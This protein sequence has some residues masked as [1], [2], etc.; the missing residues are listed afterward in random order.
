MADHG[1][2]VTGLI[3]D[4]APR[5]QIRLIRI[6]NDYGG[7]DL[8]NIYAAL[9]DLEVELISGPIRRLVINLSLNIMPDI[10]RLP[11]VWF[12]HRQ[13]P[14]TQWP[15]AVGALVACLGGVG[16]A[17]CRRSGYA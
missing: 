10:R 13:W 4:V 16:L 6:L 2:F 14:T 9:T 5:A 8:Y 7:G 17:F 11:Y 15:V 3:R 1:L 12:D